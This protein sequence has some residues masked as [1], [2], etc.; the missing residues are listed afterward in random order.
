MEKKNLDNIN[1]V[2]QNQIE[3][4][5]IAGAAIKVIHKNEICFQEVYGNAILETHTPI[6]KDTIFRMHSMSKPITTVAAMI[7]FERGQLNLFSPVSDYLD[8]FCNQKVLTENGLEDVKS[9]VTIQHLLNMTSGIVYPDASFEAGRMMSKLFD[10]V[11]AAKHNGNPVNTLDFCNKIGQ[12]PLEF[13]PGESWRYGA[14]ADILGT[15]IEV[16]SGKKLGQFLQEEI[17]TPLNM[18]DT[19]FF[20]P[21]EKRERFAQIYEYKEDQNKLEVFTGDFLA[22]F[23]YLAP[24]EF[25]SGGAGLVSTIEDYSNFA[26]MLAN[27]GTYNGVRILGRKTVEHIA[28][29]QLTSK[30]ALAYNWESLY[31]YSYGN[32][33]R[34]MTDTAKAASNG[35]IGEFGWDGWSGC[36]FFVEPKEQLVMIY[37]LQRCDGTGTDYIRKLRNIVFGAL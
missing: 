9:P 35:S 22:I 20:V 34:V 10:E 33:C 19:A 30:Q 14:S 17:F 4:G 24:P 13:H 23:D 2:I 32:F 26:S 29:P 28:T 5:Q 8:G 6:R 36:Y 1:S 3:K 7:L 16:V 11:Q 25:E 15:V 27:G 18:I 37:M 31:G 12:M 21:E